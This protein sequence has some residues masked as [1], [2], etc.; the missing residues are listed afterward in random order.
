MC[1]P[2]PSRINLRTSY[3]SAHR[4]LKKMKSIT[5]LD[6][7]QQSRRPQRMYVLSA[8]GG[9]WKMSSHIAFPSLSIPVADL[10]SPQA[11][12]A[13]FMQVGFPSLSIDCLPKN[14]INKKL[15]NIFQLYVQDTISRAA[16]D[17]TLPFVFV[18]LVDLRFYTLFFE[19]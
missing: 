9:A 12:T 6:P 1:T 11:S 17:T 10:P 2:K 19:W 3:L 18:F 15:E 7:C 8:L 5:N 14:N 13:L 4:S 16:R